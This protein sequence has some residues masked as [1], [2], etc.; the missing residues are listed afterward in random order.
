MNRIKLKYPLLVEGNYDK[1]RV[2]AVA[3]GTV[4]T[5]NGFGVFNN[6]EKKALLRRITENGKLLVLTDSDGAGMLIRNKL[7]GYLNPNSIINL[8]TPALKGTEKRKKQPSKAGLLGVEGMSDEVLISLLAPFALDGDT[9]ACS[10]PVTTTLLYSAGF[11]GGEN[12]TELRAQFCRKAGLPE[13]LTPKAFKE[14]V[15]L[16]GGVAFFEKIL[17]EIKV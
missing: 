5:T 6:A 7:K 10:E 2:M 17:A 9:A 3:D 8:Y 16:L 14:A 13:S 15:N 12:S 4:I 11:T 1:N